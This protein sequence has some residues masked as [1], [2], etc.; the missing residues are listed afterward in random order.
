MPYFL[1]FKFM[2]TA[3]V[4][5]NVCN[6]DLQFLHICRKLTRKICKCNSPKNWRIN[7]Y[8]PLSIC[9]LIFDILQ[10]NAIFFVAWLSSLKLSKCSLPISNMNISDYRKRKYQVQIR[11]KK[12]IKYFFK[13]EINLISS[14]D[15][16]RKILILKCT[17]KV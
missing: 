14:T 9:S 7:L 15:G 17:I 8:L 1:W 6:I 16:Y 3:K 10:F 4:P 12:F 13:F 2:I 11:K 5:I